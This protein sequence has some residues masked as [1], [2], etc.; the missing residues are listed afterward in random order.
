MTDPRI[1]RRNFLGL[2]GGALT[3]AATPRLAFADSDGDARFVLVILRGAMD[4][5]ALAPPYGDGSY[6]RLRGELALAAPGRD[7]GVLRL[8]GLFGL[9][10][11]MANLHSAFERGDALIV[12]AVASPYRDRSHFD[13]QDHLESG[14][15]QAHALRDGWLNRAIE[16]IGGTLGDETAIAMAQTTPYVLRGSHSVTTWAPSYLRDADEDT[17]TRLEAL[18]ADDP[19]FSI[20]LE[21]ALR[22]QEIAAGMPAGSSRRR[23]GNAALAATM[24]S[25]A[26]FL[27]APD[28]PRIA[29]IESGGWDTH[30]NQ[31][32]ATGSLAN[33]LRALDQG[34]ATL[35][36]EL[37]DDWDRTVVAVVTEFGRTARVN[38][39]RGT[40]HGT[41]TAAILAGGA[42]DGGRVVSDWPGLRDRD[43]YA[44]RDLAPTTDLR[45]V[46]KSILV[47]HLGIDPAFVDHSVFPNSAAA[48]LLDGL[49]SI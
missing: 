27:S 15:G 41:A 31:G 26:R 38:G 8:D 34:L 7:G 43:L 22:S 10:P 21:Q 39:T 32:G 6:N 19:F 2:A 12:H 35:E 14:S 18:Y 47:E 28:G 44:G 1:N 49:I 45:S 4:G 23:R 37:G 3:L 9:H 42:V 13:G 16:P 30:A 40:D 11:A 24:T 48:P 20:R 25:A 5:L 17:I 29:V 46:F 33:N 36:H